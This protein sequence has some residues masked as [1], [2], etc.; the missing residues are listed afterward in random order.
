MAHQFHSK[1]MSFVQWMRAR[2]Q[3]VAASS[4]WSE[5]L[6]LKLGIQAAG[7]FNLEIYAE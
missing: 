4:I 5:L 3:V 2:R 1:L 6:L 7:E